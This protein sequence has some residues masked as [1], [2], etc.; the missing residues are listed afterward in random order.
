MKTIWRQAIEIT[1]EQV[2]SAPGLYRVLAVEDR[3]GIPE[4][5]FEAD[6]DKELAEVTLFVI[7]TGNP[8]PDEV[9]Q[10][11]EYIG[12]FL[13]LDNRFVGHVYASRPRFP[14]ES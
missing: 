2:I 9:D 6:P 3:R 12:H 4:V 10:L 13:A 8:I 14:A 11:G 5:W 1:D 7:G